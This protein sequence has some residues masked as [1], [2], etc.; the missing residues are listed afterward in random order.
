ME[1]FDKNEYPGPG[2]LGL[3]R[4]HFSRLAAASLDFALTSVS[5]ACC[6]PEEMQHKQYQAHDQGHVNESGGH[7]KCEKPQQPKND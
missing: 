5:N 3:P 1:M 7:M 6:A 4:C 2:S